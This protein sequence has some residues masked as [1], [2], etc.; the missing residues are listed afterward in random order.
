M[1]RASVA[2]ETGGNSISCLQPLSPALQITMPIKFVTLFVV[3]YANQH[4][5]R[6]AADPA[7]R[8]V[9]LRDHETYELPVPAAVGAAPTTVTTTTATPPTTTPKHEQVQPVAEAAPLLIS[10]DCHCPPGPRG[11]RGAPGYGYSGQKGDRGP[12]GPPGYGWPGPPGA[13]GAPGMKGQPG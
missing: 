5:P 7:V 4:L 3:L 9:Q 10:C 8:V 6:A 2:R 1:E 12:P 13:I 11:T